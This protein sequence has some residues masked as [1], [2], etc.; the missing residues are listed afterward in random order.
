VA[1]TAAKIRGIGEL[2]ELVATNDQKYDSSSTGKHQEYEFSTA[3][4]ILCR[5]LRHLTPQN[6]QE[7][8]YSPGNK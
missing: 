1:E 5:W 6:C 4:Y 2:H 8:D 7:K 3:F